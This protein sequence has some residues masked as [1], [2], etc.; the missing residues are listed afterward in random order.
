[1]YFYYCSVCF[2]GVQLK[3]RVKITETP[4]STENGWNDRV[5]ICVWPG[6]GV[7][8]VWD[9]SRYT[10][11]SEALFV[12]LFAVGDGLLGSNPVPNP[13]SIRRYNVNPHP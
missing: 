13:N 7:V 11:L 3:K 10:A 6:R 9:G 5:C 1:M 4:S 8:G 12:A 2:G